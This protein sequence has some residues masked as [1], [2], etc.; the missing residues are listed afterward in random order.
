MSTTAEQRTVK[1]D[2]PRSWFAGRSEFIVA[3]I[4][5]VLA[6]LL[7]I[8][9]VTMDVP[10]ASGAPGPQFFPAVVSG[11][12][13]VLAIVLSVQVIRAPRDLDGSRDHTSAQTSS[14]MLSD[15]GVID[16]TSEIRVIRNTPKTATK[17][18][19]G[20]DWKTVG[21]LFGALVVF[22]LL[23]E[24][25]GWIIMAAALFWAVCFALGGKRPIFD[26]SVSVLFSSA[27]QIAFSAGLGLNLPAGI[28][29]GVTSWIN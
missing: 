19:T 22:T 21:I 15:I 12:L 1:A 17:A 10:S 7:T 24:T 25:I 18:P 5:A 9:T 23:L 27:I 26:I 29:A 4:V 8:G 14:D 3:G 13:F 2:A 6:V 11:L 28:L 20:I 16:A